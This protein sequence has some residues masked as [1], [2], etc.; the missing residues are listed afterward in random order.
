MEENIN[1]K[2]LLSY[3]MVLNLDNQPSV[4]LIPG[5]RRNNQEQPSGV[6]KKIS[7]LVGERSQGRAPAMRRVAG[8]WLAS[9]SR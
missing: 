7:S 4:N 5:N 6:C 8:G 2:I 1:E 9:D 3:T